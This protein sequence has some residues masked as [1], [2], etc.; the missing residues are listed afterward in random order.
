M[1]LVIHPAVEAT[2]L[3]RIVET[4][5]AATIVNASSQADALH[6]IVDADALFGK[7]TPELLA[8]AGRLRWIQAPTASMEHYL[9]AELVQHPVVV[10]NMRGI[11]GDV[12]AEHVLGMLL[13]LVRNLHI[14]ARQQTT[15]RW[16][17]E[18][19]ENERADFVTGPGV[20][21]A[22]DRAHGTLAGGTLGI[23]GLG[24]I[25]SELAQR[26]MAL[27]MRVVAVD[28]DTQPRGGVTALFPP[29]QLEQLLRQSDFVVIAA[30]HTPQ[31]ERWIGR[32]QLQAMKPTAW[33]I[34]VGRG[35]I[36]VLDDLVEALRAGELAGAG[37]DVCET[38]PLPSTH[39]LWR[40]PNVLITPHV[41]AQSTRI[42]ERH[43]AVFLDNLR[44]FVAGHP[45]R[46]V[47]DKH[48]WY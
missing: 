48:R 17:P 36:L 7:I 23:V 12:I 43:L 24:Q 33:L 16:E 40:M 10:T 4:A 34:N 13:A 19:G 25:G 37:L 5:P 11:Y 18:G 44:R 32:R 3:A 29:E 15:G 31:T 39:P 20:T 8:A 14:Y 42:A 6:A 9:F 45:L 41:A 2:R 22:I 26:A 30:P 46:N 35:A 38:E 47:V 27:G 1:K 28:P 21:S